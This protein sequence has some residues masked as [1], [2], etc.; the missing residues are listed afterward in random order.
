MDI[1][2]RLIMYYIAWTFNISVAF[3]KKKENDLR[4]LPRLLTILRKKHLEN[5]VGKKKY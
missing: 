1:V 5:I 4:S 3:K 2:L